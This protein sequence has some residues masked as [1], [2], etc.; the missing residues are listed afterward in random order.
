MK[1]KRKR[2]HE[3]IEKL[4]VDSYLS[5]MDRRKAE[6]LK[7]QQQQQQDKEKQQPQQKE[8]QVDAP[9][10]AGRRKEEEGRATAWSKTVK[11][12]QKDVVEIDD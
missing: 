5:D 10:A 1:E 4:H 11:K 9:A 2:I 7:K 3:L 12:G 8:I 6:D